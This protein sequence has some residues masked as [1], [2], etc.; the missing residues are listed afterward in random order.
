MSN[1]D[2]TESEFEIDAILNQMINYLE[3]GVMVT[4]NVIASTVRP[5]WK[6][7]QAEKAW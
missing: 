6:S 1:I 4:G 3:G 7:S 5:G 2:V